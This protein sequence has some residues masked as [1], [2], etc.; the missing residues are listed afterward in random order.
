MKQYWVDALPIDDTH[1]QVITD[2]DAI[3]TPKRY[4]E[5]ISLAGMPMAA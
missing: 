4:L 5:R 1:G 2:Q 3:T